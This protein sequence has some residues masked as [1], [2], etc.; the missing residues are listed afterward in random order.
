MHKIASID[1]IFSY[2]LP[3]MTFMSF[4]STV[5][6]TPMF[7]INLLAQKIKVLL[8]LSVVQFKKKSATLAKVLVRR[9]TCALFNA[10]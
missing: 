2:I 9:Q 7:N 8:V 1:D 10:Q 5:G 3:T 6:Q 4:D